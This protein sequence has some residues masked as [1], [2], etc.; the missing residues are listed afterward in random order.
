VA[1]HYEILADTL[2][3]FF[4]EPYHESMRKRQTAKSKFYFFD[5]GVVRALK[6]Q[7][8]ETLNSSTHEF[9]ELFE[10][11]MM[12]EFVKLRSALNLRWKFSYL[13]TKD[14]IEVDL[15][16]EK[17]TG[18]PILIEFK[19]KDKIGKQDINSL[20]KIGKDLGHSQCYLL[21]RDPKPTEIEGVRCLPW[22]QG[23]KEIFAL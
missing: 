1:R 23:L 19:S 10:T 5:M 16:I 13:R 14:D 11:F 2:I 15:I 3:G 22:N 6:D 21:S 8:G 20:T 18:L 17:P 12:N 9:G 7:A 4:L